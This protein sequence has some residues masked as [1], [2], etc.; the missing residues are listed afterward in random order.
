MANGYKKIRYKLLGSQVLLRENIVK[1]N[2]TCT[3][4]TFC[5]PY[6]Y[7]CILTRKTAIVVQ[8]E[9][10]LKRALFKIITYLIEVKM[11]WRTPL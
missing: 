1:G 10:R 8:W 5:A 4:H 2:H 7:W 3:T 11:A 9:S 6:I